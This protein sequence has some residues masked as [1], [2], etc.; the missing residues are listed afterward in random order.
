MVQARARYIRTTW[1][2]ATY[3]VWG[4][5]CDCPGDYCKSDCGYIVNNRFATA[6]VILWLRVHKVNAGTSREFEAATPSDR[7]VRRVLGIRPGTP[8]DCV[9]DDVDIYPESADSYPLGELTCTSHD[10]LSP[11]RRRKARKA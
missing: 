9:G 5:P 2:P 4:G 6:E 8:I 7:Q 1:Q 10:S 11:I 3:D